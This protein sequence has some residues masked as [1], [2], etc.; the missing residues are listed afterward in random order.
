MPILAISSSNLLLLS[1]LSLA[2]YGIVLAVYRLLFHPLSRFP[3]PKLAAATYWRSFYYD[4]LQGPYPGRE[5]YDIHQLHNRY[6][7]YR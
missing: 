1:I 5:L 2:G 6:G 7:E 3:G 4:I